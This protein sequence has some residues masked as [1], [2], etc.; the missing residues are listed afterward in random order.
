MKRFVLSI[1]IA[2]LWATSLVAADLKVAKAPP[3][4]A[5]SPFDVAFGATLVSDYNFRGITQS[6]H[7]PSVWAY[8]EPRYDIIKDLQLAHIDDLR[9]RQAFRAVLD[10]QESSSSTKTKRQGLWDGLPEA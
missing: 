9:L 7:K 1:A 6:N 10:L 3:A 5:P 2:M 4:P 8:F